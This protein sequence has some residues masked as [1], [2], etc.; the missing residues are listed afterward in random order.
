MYYF[1]MTDM[2]V[3][4]IYLIKILEIVLSCLLVTQEFTH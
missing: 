4:A 3:K 2:K 1:L